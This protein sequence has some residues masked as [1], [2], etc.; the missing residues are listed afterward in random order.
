MYT[1]MYQFRRGYQSRNNLVQDE[2]SYLLADSHNIL[3]RR[4]NYLPKLLSVHNASHVRQIE[5]HMAP[6][7]LK[8]KLLLQS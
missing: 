4:K 7:V 6:V 8:L 5:V 3:N 1:G 2:N